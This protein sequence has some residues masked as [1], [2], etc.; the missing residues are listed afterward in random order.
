MTCGRNER[1]RRTS[2]SAA[3]ATSISPKQPSGSGGS[4]SPSGQPGVDPAQPVLAYAEDLARRVHLRAADGRE[5]GQHVGVV[6]QPRIEDGS[7]LPAGARDDVHV[8]ALRAR[9]GPSWPRPCSTR[10][11]GGRAP[12]SS[13][14]CRSRENH[15]VRRRR[16]LPPGDPDER[17]TAREPADRSARRPLR[18]GAARSRPARSLALAVLVAAA[19]VGW[20]A[21]A[22]FASSGPAVSGQVS[23]FDVRGQHLIRVDLLVTGD[24]GRV[25]CR[26][27]AQG[28]RSR[29]RRRDDE[30]PAPGKH[31]AGRATV[32][33]RTRDTAVTAVV[34][35]CDP[36]RR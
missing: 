9:S 28:P 32:A 25:A 21:W 7:P 33:V 10:R 14:G 23:G 24:P 13:A 20:A 12:P 17:T 26:V 4:G 5:V 1:T 29:R 15:P 3:T 6:L 2:G 19:L 30:P 27:Q 11:R 35:G 34:Q 18:R 8:D 31:R 22:T 36:A 16:P